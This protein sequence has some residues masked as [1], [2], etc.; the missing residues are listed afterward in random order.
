[1]QSHETLRVILILSNEK[2][3]NVLIVVI[4]RSLNEAL[5]ANNAGSHPAHPALQ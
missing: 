4:H 1:M 2:G 5:P 3:V